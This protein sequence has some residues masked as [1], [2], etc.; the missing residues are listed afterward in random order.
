L[1]AKQASH[2]RE[3]NTSIH[4]ANP[5]TLTAAWD[6]RRR[7]PIEGVPE[8]LVPDHCR[9]SPPASVLFQHGN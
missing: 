7:Q 5:L 3:L 2:W 6:D 8:R 4:R 9:S 1:T